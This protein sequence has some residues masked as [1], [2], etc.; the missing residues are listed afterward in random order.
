MNLSFSEREYLRRMSE[1]QHFD[2]ECKKIA[3]FNYIAHF[4]T[5]VFVVPSAW[6]TM[7][8]PRC[9]DCSCLPSGR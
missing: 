5:T 6:R 3:K 9:G 7:F 4:T 2:G 1:I 8:R